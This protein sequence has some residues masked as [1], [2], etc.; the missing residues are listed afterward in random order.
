MLPLFQVSLNY[1][2]FGHVVLPVTVF[3]GLSEELSSS[4]NLPTISLNYGFPE[5]SSIGFRRL[6]LAWKNQ[7]E[8]FL[9][10][11]VERV[12]QLVDVQL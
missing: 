6:G 12:Y 3:P 11:T 5:R 4:C 2:D 1:H 7:I 9:Q 10:V 8:V